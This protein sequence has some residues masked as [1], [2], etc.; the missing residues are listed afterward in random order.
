MIRA[1]GGEITQPDC[2]F[3]RGDDRDAFES[4]QPGPAALSDGLLRL[5]TIGCAPLL[6]SATQRKTCPRMIRGRMLLAEP[7]VV[8]DLKIHCRLDQRTRVVVF[9]SGENPVRLTLFNHPA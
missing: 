4:L 2:L 9:G 6:T 1:H 8:P 7:S 5:C 3:G